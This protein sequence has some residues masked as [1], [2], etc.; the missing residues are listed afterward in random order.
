[1]TAHARTASLLL[2][3]CVLIGARVAGQEPGA[4]APEQRRPGNPVQPIELRTTVS[5]TAVWVGDR[6]VY[7]IEL[8][9]APGVDVL[10]D[11]LMKERIQ[12]QGGEILSVEPQRSESDGRIIHRF[13]YTLATFRVDAT[14]IHL[15]TLPV[16]YY[17]RG[18]GERRGDGAPAGE[19]AIPPLTVAVGTTVPESEGAIRLRSPGGTRAAPIQLRLA[20]PVGL[21]LVLLAIVPVAFS[22]LGVTRRIRAFRTAYNA[23]RS[24]KRQRG[25]FDQIKSLQPGSDEERIEAYGQ[26]DEFLRDHLAM[27]T[28]IAAHSLTPTDVKRALLDR[29]PQ[30]PH[31]AIEAVLEACERARYAPE[32]P[33]AAEWADVVRDAEAVLRAPRR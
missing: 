24:G 16:R 19:V 3:L 9:C 4:A 7:T 17:V 20:Q 26:L 29:A 2:A 14:A 22:V 28:G 23:R 27:T 32:P 31:D 1:M 12:I 15:A 13:T 33:A 25:S 11:D 18:R 10:L 5:R 30:I 21:G 8:R 6:V